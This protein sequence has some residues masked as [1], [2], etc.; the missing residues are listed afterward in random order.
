M[1]SNAPDLADHLERIGVLK[2]PAL[3][4]AFEAVDRADFVPESQKENAYADEPLPIGEGQTISQPYTVAFM[5]EQ[6]QPLEGERILDIGAG[7]GWQA[8][9]LAHIVGG[10]GRVVAIER[11]RTLCDFGRRNVSKYNFIQKG[12]VDWRC[13][14][15]SLGAPDEEPFDGIIAAAALENDRIPAVWLDGLRIGGRLL[16]PISGSLWKWTKRAGELFDKE[17][18]PGFAFVPFVKNHDR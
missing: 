13:G 5:L 3:K 6:L 14:D 15:A 2:M 7:S 12:I 8:A 10:K 9:L 1:I 4:K 17:E 16:F 11:I 18:F